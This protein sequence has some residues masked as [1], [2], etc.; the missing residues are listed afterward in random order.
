MTRMIIPLNVGFRQLEWTIKQDTI[1]REIIGIKNT[2][3]YST[4]CIRAKA[5]ENSIYYG[6]FNI[7]VLINPSCRIC[8]IDSTA[9][10]SSKYDSEAC[11]GKG[12]RV[13]LYKGYKLHLITTTDDLI[14]TIS[15][16][17][18]TANKYDNQV[19]ELLYEAKT[20]SPFLILGDAAYDDA[21]W[22]ET[23]ESLELNLLT[24]VNMRNA[25][26]IESF[27]NE[28]RYK[29]ALFMKSP[30]GKNNLKID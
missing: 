9:L 3:N 16:Q 14:I 15:F 25:T 27:S 6:I 5:I 11:F 12:T 29:N 30:I 1:F 20:F 2:P 26:N 8:S 17:I 10:R 23:A 24:D 28:H 18:T 13:G 22:F 7:L 19:V 4:L 21:D